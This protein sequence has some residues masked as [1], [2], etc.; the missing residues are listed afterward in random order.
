MMGLSADEAKS[1][2]QKAWESI[3]AKKE[4][5]ENGWWVE[6]KLH[7]LL[8]LFDYDWSALAER[9]HQTVQAN[10]EPA[11]HLT[12][13]Q[14]DSA[15]LHNLPSGDGSEALLNELAQAGPQ[16]F[17]ALLAYLAGKPSARERLS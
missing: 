17:A 3:L 8:A 2:Q 12:G 15:N 16:S 9:L 1:Q 4:W 6:D 11:T 13:P 14:G 7:D 10:G 5:E